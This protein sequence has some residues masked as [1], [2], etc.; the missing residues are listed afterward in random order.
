MATLRLATRGSPLARWQAARVAGLIGALPG[1]PDCELVVLQTTG[2]RLS[3]VPVDQLG[4][5]GAFVTEIQE[6]VRSGR[7]DVAVHSAKDLPSTTPAGLVLG[8]I[9][10]RADPRDALVGS[11]LADLPAGGRVA[12][13]SVRRRAQLAWL[14]PD[15]TFV[16][17]RGNMARRLERAGREGAGVVA[18]AALERLGLTAEIAEVLETG[19]LL[20]QVAQGALAGECR[21]DDA[22]TRELLAGIDDLVAHRAVTAERAFLAAL[23][24]GCSLPVGALASPSGFAGGVGGVGGV[25]EAVEAGS[26]RLALEGMLASRDGRILLRRRVEGDDP[27]EIGRRLA[28]D[29][30]ERGGRMLDDWAPDGGMGP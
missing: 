12:T 10:E 26:R 18:V 7:A 30:L 29:L 9:P 20:P 19:T 21:E 8:C 5:Q 23:G 6:A 25:A 17:L 14:R 3:E 1:A 22:G 27:V 13:G 4:G 2:D 11:S 24:S 15:L 28:G 16:E